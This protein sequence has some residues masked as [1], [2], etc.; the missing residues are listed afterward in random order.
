MAAEVVWLDQALDDLDALAVYLEP[1]NPRAATAYAD[2]IWSASERL[3][4]FPRSGRI[5]F[6]EFRMIVV[7]NHLLFYRYDLQPNQIRIV[8]VL[9]GRMDY[10]RLLGLPPTIESD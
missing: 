2:A 9:D 10:P 7:R 4:S 1:L 5:F 3:A 8:R 6:D